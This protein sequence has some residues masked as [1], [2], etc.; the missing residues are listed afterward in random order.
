MWILMEAGPCIEGPW[1]SEVAIFQLQR[2][3]IYYQDSLEIV[4]LPVSRFVNF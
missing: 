3:H 1:L 2:Q 4:S